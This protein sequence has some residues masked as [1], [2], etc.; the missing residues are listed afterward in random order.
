MINDQ[1]CQS[2]NDI[3]YGP[4]D[5]EATQKPSTGHE[6]CQSLGCNFS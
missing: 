1:S 2:S 6:Q 3:Y 5:L 4:S